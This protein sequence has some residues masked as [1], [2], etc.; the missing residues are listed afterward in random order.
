MCVP[1]LALHIGAGKADHQQVRCCMKQKRR[2][3]NISKLIV[4][5]NE[6]QGCG[7]GASWSLSKASHASLH[8]ETQEIGGFERFA[9]KEC[10]GVA[11]HSSQCK[12]DWTNTYKCWQ[13][14]R[15]K[16]TAS[17]MLQDIFLEGW[18]SESQLEGIFFKPTD[19][20][21]RR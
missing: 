15:S 18:V 3:A 17:L 7:R 9:H 6:R 2:Q 8:R 19:S 20:K 12:M 1:G 14:I 4:L 13:L 10:L 11:P 5:P 21:I 16:L